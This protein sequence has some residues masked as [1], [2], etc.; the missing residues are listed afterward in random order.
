MISL[1]L[2]DAIVSFNWYFLDV[3]IYACCMLSKLLGCEVLASITNNNV[4][5][6][7]IYINPTIRNVSQVVF[8]LIPLIKLAA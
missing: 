6:T 5:G 2:A 8:A 7:L 4:G 3:D 1:Y